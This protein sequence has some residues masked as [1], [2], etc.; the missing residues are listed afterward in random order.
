MNTLT[1]P[2]RHEDIGIKERLLF[3]LPFEFATS[4]APR[5]FTRSL[6]V[7]VRY[8]RLIN[9]LGRS[10]D[11]ERLNAAAYR[12]E[13]RQKRYLGRGT[14][15]ISARAI[16]T[17][18]HDDE[19]K[20]TVIRGFLRFGGQYTILLSLMT[21]ATITSLVML[22]FTLLFLPVSLLMFMVLALH[23]GYLFAD[24]RDLL[25]RLDDLVQQRSIETDYDINLIEST[26]L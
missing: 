15:A 6:S 1:K 3:A 25:N 20:L 2:K 8:P 23:W 9:D 21:L 18:S 26:H 5:D 4:Q 11:S 24:R 7:L 10:V 13:I 14:Y 22:F 17:I 16:G 12:F 19:N